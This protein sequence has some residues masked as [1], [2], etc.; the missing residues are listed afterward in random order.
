M[1]NYNFRRLALAGLAALLLPIGL[2]GQ[3]IAD[4]NIFTGATP[5]P[6]NEYNDGIFSKFNVNDGTASQFYFSDS[7]TDSTL[8]FSGFS[9]PSG[10]NSIRFYD[11]E[12][13]QV[14]RVATQVTVYATSNT[15]TGTSALEDKGNYTEV[16][17]F[18]LSTGPGGYYD[19]GVDANVAASHPGYAPS[20]DYTGTGYGSFDTISGLNLSANT[21]EVLLDFGAAQYSDEGYNVGQGFTEIQAF[22]VA[23]EPSTYAMMLGGLA[24]LGLCVRRKLA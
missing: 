4:S 10:I 15:L 24:I 23:P 13:Y 19:G 6:N 14:A 12:T 7:S 11:A 3:T 2:H 17:Y 8:T 21:K 9:D 16:G 22:A 5:T 18:T 20:G 1:M